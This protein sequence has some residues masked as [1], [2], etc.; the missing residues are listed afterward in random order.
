[1]SLIKKINLD[2]KKAILSKNKLKLESLRAIKASLIVHQTS[3]QTIYYWWRWNKNSSKAYKQRRESVKYKITKSLD[4][5]TEE[6]QADLYPSFTKTV[7]KSRDRSNC[8]KS[9]YWIK[10]KWLKDMGKL[11]EL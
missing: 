9:Y 11:L 6:D 8:Y 3:V 10:F 4:L 1:M 2:L 7:N 5:Q